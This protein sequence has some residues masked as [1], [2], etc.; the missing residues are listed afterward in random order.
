MASKRIFALLVPILSIAIIAFMLLPNR[1][2]AQDA[3]DERVSALETQV[4]LQAGEIADLQDQV[5]QLVA[6]QSNPSANA[7]SGESGAVNATTF[8]G[9]GE[10]VSDKFVLSPGNHKVTASVDIESG[11]DGFAVWVYIDGEKDL[12]FNETIDENGPWTGSAILDAGNGGEAY[13]E[14]ENTDSAWSLIVEPM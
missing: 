5:D 1:A 7:P 6:N 10:M 8:S 13:F 11:F 12:L 14:V 4:A 2:P 9:T 3:I